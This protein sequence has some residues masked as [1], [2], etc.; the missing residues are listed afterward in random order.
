MSSE[1]EAPRQLKPIYWSLQI[2]VVPV[3]PV[4]PGW[5]MVVTSS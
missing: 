5:D 1:R 3:V 2:P 4:G